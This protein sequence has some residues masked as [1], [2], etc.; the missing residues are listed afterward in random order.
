MVMRLPEGDRI[1]VSREK[2]ETD[3]AVAMGGRVAEELVFGR[4]KV[5]AGAASDIE[6]ATKIARHMVTQW[7]MS[8]TLGP[9]GY[10]ENTQEV[11]LG[12]SITQGKNISEATSQ[13]IDSEIRRIIE[14]GYGHATELLSSS[15]VQL[16]R[17]A[18][19][20][21]ERETLTG[22]DITTLMHGDPP[23]ALASRRSSLAIDA[24]R[25]PQ[26]GA[27]DLAPALGR[28]RAESPAR[29]LIRYSQR[30]E[31]GGLQAALFAS[32]DANPMVAAHR[33][34]HRPADRAWRCIA[35]QCSRPANAVLRT[36][37]PATSRQRQPG[38][39]LPAPVRPLGVDPGE[40]RQEAPVRLAD[41]HD[42]EAGL[43]YQ[44]QPDEAGVRLDRL[45]ADL[46]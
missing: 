14:G 45:Q 34:R 26:L 30:H 12:H 42:G 21:L 44:G 39:G 18:G 41:R 11:F 7:G 8:D 46:A 33:V 38:R 6:Q 4:N 36:P 1:S 16:D 23:A 29:R 22:D 9:V 19:S 2:L 31:K 17:I 3:I 15:R 32:S 5:T 20:L 24:G 40:L 13:Q 28:G 43:A 35:G 10:A 25:T 27:G 37:R